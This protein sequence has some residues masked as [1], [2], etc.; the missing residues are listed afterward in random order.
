MLLSSEDFKRIIPQVV[1]PYEDY[2]VRTGVD[3]PVV[4]FGQSYCGYDISLYHKFMVAKSSMFDRSELA[5][6]RETPHGMICDEFPVIDPKKPS[7]ENPFELIDFRK[8]GTFCLKPFQYILGVSVEYFEMP[9]DLFALVIGKSTYARTGIMINCTPIEPG[10]RG[11]LT[12]EIA[13]L[14]PFQ[15]LL[16]IYEGIAQVVFFRLLNPP[17]QGYDGKFQYQPNEPILVR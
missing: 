6:L 14:T 16:H 2:S 15:S 10:W 9:Q 3:G 4:S 8:N 7:N 11:Y 17:K 5:T 1:Q 12:L 13:N